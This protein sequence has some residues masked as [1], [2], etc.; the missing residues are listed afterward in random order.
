MLCH[1]FFPPSVPASRI[2]RQLHNRFEGLDLCRWG[3]RACISQNVG[4]I[5]DLESPLRDCLEVD[6]FCA[7]VTW[8][9]QEDEELC[10]VNAKRMDSP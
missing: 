7:P 9:E 10:H 1:H 5:T 3:E 4:G 2:D 6:M 8:R